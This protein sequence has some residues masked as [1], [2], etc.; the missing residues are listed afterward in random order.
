M[1][2]NKKFEA[3]EKLEIAINWLRDS[4]DSLEDVLNNVK[5]AEDAGDLWEALADGTL[6]QGLND[7]E[8]ALDYL[9]DAYD[10]ADNDLEEMI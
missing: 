3:L 5:S 2:D 10:V 9:K 7:V 1:L 4:A 6:E 8:A